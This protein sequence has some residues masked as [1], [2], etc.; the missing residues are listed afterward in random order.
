MDLQ[1][2]AG[3]N[4]RKER[5]VEPDSRAARRSAESTGNEGRCWFQMTT[6]RLT[7]RRSE[8]YK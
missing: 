7:N 3:R 1:E 4:E 6:K 2:G 5:E 8:L